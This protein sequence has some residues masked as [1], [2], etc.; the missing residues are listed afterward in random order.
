MFKLRKME[1]IAHS[2]LVISKGVEQ[3]TLAIFETKDNE[4]KPKIFLDFD[5]NPWCLIFPLNLIIN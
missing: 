4:S 3:C 5:K 2:L 1:G